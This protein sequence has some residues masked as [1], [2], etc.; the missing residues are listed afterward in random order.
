MTEQPGD[1][2]DA[3]EIRAALVADLRRAHRLAGPDA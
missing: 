3:A 2:E 1:Q